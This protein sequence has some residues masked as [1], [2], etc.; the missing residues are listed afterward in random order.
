[1]FDLFYISGIKHFYKTWIKIVH[2]LYK[3]V[4]SPNYTKLF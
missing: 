1:M 2:M 3:F 4:P